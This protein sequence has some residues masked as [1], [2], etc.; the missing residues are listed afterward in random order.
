MNVVMPKMGESVSEGTIIKWHKKVGDAVKVDEIIF[1]IST[2]K[3]DTEIPSP[4]AGVL[5]EIKYNEGDTVDV[6]TV[7]AVIDA[8]GE[9]KKAQPEQAKAEIKEEPKQEEAKA[10]VAAP[11][12]VEE[13]KVESV[14]DSEPTQVSGGNITEI[15]MPKMGESVMEGTIIKWHKKV[16]ETIKK[17]ETFFEIS[18]DKVDTEVPSPVEG[19][20]SEIL[21]A[22]QETV[23]VGTIVAKISSGGNV[24]S[25]PAAKAESKNEA[26]SKKD[27]I[28]AEE[29]ET[30]SSKHENYYDS[31]ATTDIAAEAKASNKFLSPL[32]LNIIRKENVSFDEIDNIQGTGVEGRITKK[33]I[34]SYIE[35]RKTQKVEPAQTKAAPVEQKSQTASQPVSA[36]SQMAPVYS[37]DD[38][39]KIPMDN[40]RQKIMQ[41]MVNSRDTSVHVSAMLE[42]DMA[43]VYNFIQKNRE[44]YL[45]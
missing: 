32:V 5:S 25:S 29:K 17:D 6:G 21:V 11:A 19:V 9:V 23:E 7:V 8:D 15:Q 37:S 42:V 13:K 41:H 45:K 38:V 20:V 36:P 22:E 16:G 4:S 39:E 1:E 27:Q 26:E 31:K 10:E 34:L 24:S 3:V 44:E 40:I 35:N 30:P 2:D 33:D 18:T 28:E 12:K 14:Q 43:K